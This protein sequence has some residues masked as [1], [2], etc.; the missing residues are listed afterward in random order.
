[1]KFGLI[2]RS[3]HKSG[4]PMWFELITDLVLGSG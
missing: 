1:V 3:L 2:L 4:E